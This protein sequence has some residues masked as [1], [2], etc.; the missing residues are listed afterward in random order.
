MSCASSAAF[1]RCFLQ[2]DPVKGTIDERSQFDGC[3]SG[4]LSEQR[5]KLAERWQ[6]RMPARG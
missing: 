1:L 2:G 3:A 6:R 5:A 4:H